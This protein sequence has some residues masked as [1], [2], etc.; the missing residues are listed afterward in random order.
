MEKN[1]LTPETALKVLQERDAPLLQWMGKISVTS[2]E[3][4]KHCEANLIMAK[5]AHAQA[6]AMRKNLVAPLYEAIKRINALFNP[7][8]S[9]LQL[10]INASNKTLSD[11]RIY[12]KQEAERLLDTV[13]LDYADKIKESK[14]TGEKV[15]P[16]ILPDLN[17]AKTSHSGPGYVSY[18]DG[19]EIVIVNDDKVPRDLCKA[20]MSKIRARVKSGARVI[21]GVAITPKYTMRTKMG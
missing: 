8:L 4:Q 10:G 19:F 17:I 12:S 18:M 20:D 3:E 2:K 11:W 5:K 1:Q 6:D 21:E 9:R 15:E 14:I 13:A 16:P 7:Y